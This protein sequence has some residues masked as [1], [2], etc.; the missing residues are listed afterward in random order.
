MKLPDLLIS[1]S[2]IIQLVWEENTIEFFSEVVH[3]DAESVYV[4][5]YL[6]NGS[7]LNLNIAE[8]A[9]V[10]CNIFT[11]D[12]TTRQRI[13][14][15]NVE[16]STVT[17]HNEVLYC[18]KTHG[19]NNVANPD[20]RRRNER[21]VVE[22]KG[23]VSDEHEEETVEVTVHDISSDGISFYVPNSYSPKSQQLRIT[24][25]D[26]IDGKTFMI[27]VEC[28]ITRMNTEGKHTIVGCRLSG[29]NK[30]F[31]L[32]RFVKHLKM[33]GKHKAHADS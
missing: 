3:K 33:K 1:Q 14:W 8:G 11:N 12:P 7:A 18:V 25:E 10:V 32:Y 13:S 24:F 17:K 6:H 27:Q 22:A 5:P 2:I 23:Q 20:D 29:D 4:T 15:R 30:D 19:F 16:L 31:Q 21:T 26:E 28:G 9:S